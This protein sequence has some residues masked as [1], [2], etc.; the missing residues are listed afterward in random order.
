MSGFK[1]YFSRQSASYAQFRPHY[2]QALFRDLAALVSQ[3][4]CAW[5]CATGNGQAALGLSALFRT[6][7]ASDA[8]WS[9]LQQ[10][11]AAP[12]V[13]YLAASAEQV[14]LA[15]AS[16]QLITVAQALHW[17]DRPAFYREVRRVLQPG[18]VLSV[19]SYGTLQIGADIDAAIEEIYNGL[20][21]ADWPPERR[22]VDEGYRTIDFPFPEITLPDYT[23]ELQ[24][25]LPQ[26]LGYL[27]SWSAVVRHRRRTGVDPMPRIEEILHRVWA[28]PDA[29]RTIAWPLH[30]RAGRIG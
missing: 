20:L 30:V 14:P 1:D 12:N 3:P 2:P 22:L 4:L 27:S 28:A 8:S 18:G 15:A 7:V 23:L 21:G 25:Q 11:A 17:F 5:D 24:W 10:A 9:Q 13:Y 26:L 16:V 19:W 29:T 6:V